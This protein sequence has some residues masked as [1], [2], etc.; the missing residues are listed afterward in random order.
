MYREVLISCKAIF[1]KTDRKIIVIVFRV[2]C[3]SEVETR[4]QSSLH[5]HKFMIQ[6]V[7]SSV[8]FYTVR[9]KRYE[10]EMYD[11]LITNDHIFSS[12]T[13]NRQHCFIHNINFYL[14]QLNIY[15]MRDGVCIVGIGHI[16][17]NQSISQFNRARQFPQCRCF[18][19]WGMTKF[20]TAGVT[21]VKSWALK[22]IFNIFK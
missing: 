7:P 9:S 18:G 2:C 14:N 3:I 6:D 22:E 16:S 21:Q 8:I 10:D 4:Q 15:M 12:F 19:S 13:L 1:Y 5:Y 11:I 20:N 17:C